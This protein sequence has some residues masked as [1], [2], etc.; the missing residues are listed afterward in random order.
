M[1]TPAPLRLEPLTP[2]HADAALALAGRTLGRDPYQASPHHLHWLSRAVPDGPD[3]PD[4]LVAVRGDDVVG[5]VHRL[6]LPWR[7]ADG[8]V[9]VPAV[10]DL[11]VEPGEPV[12]T[13]MLLLRG[14]VR[15]EPTW[16]VPASRGLGP[17]LQR[18][19]AVELP[20]RWWR[21]PLV[22]GPRT[23]PAVRRDADP[24]RLADRTVA[25][26]GATAGAVHVVARPDRAALERIAAVLATEGPIAWD[27]QLVAWRLFH[28]TGPLNL[29]L[30]AADAAAV[31]ALGWRGRV[32][33]ARL[34]AVRGTPAA[35]TDLARE[36]P[37]LARRA[38]AVVLLAT[39]PPEHDAAARA[40]GLRAVAEPPTTWLHGWSGPPPRYDG[41]LG[42][43]G[44]DG[45]PRA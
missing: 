35:V 3:A 7:T 6:R 21:R 4:S 27:A 16:L 5:L 14:A 25:L 23:V 34:V 9:R 37:R 19:G 11:A 24:S 22:P 40:A 33:L 20:A 1:A 30:E 43:L 44:L 32:P 26:D 31:M 15:A 42:D 45:I 12:G 39:L 18:M 36:V 10:V 13:A 29:W 38:G 28:R 2:V 41:L 17:G 8:P